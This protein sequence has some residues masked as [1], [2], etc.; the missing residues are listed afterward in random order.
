MDEPKPKAPARHRH[1]AWPGKLLQ[2]FHNGAGL[3]SETWASWK[4]GQQL[5]SHAAVLPVTREEAAQLRKEWSRLLSSP[6]EPPAPT[7]EEKTLINRITQAVE[8]ANRNNVTRTAA[9][10]EMYRKHPE[11]HW[12]FLAHMVSR[13]GGWSMTDLHGELH[14]HL[15]DRQAR[16]DLFLFLE[17]ANALIFQD[18]Y[19]QL[20]LYEESVRRGTPLFRLLPLLHVSA[21]M[22]PAWELFWRSRGSTAALTVCLIINEQHYIEER[23][24]RNGY[25]QKQVLNTLAFE[26]QS[27]LQMN[28]VLLPYRPDEDRGHRLAGAILEDFKDLNERIGI[29]KALYGMLFGIP[30]VLEGATAFARQHPHTGSRADYSPKLYSSIRK[31]PPSS[32][33]T[34]RLQGCGLRPG[35]YPLY[36][37]PL[38]A[39]WKDHPVEKPER[40]DWFRDLSA[41]SWLTPIRV[42]VS[43]ERTD[44]ACAALQKLEL[45]VLAAQAI[46]VDGG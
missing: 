37:P 14:P 4:T 33:Y 20:L 1:Q 22:R 21:F 43:I 45:A 19:P 25:Y 15:L 36:S 13:N 38:H 35:A 31:A 34:E 30:E 3:L 9:Y 40:Y 5:S 24:V 2:W 41:A 29:G 42:P 17:R 46:G 11:L 7:A 12:A 44:D 18:A 10:G 16:R 27:L 32:T 28:Q 23:V 39:A 26:T 8:A 6:G